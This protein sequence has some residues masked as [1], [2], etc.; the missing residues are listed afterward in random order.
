MNQ[1]APVVAEPTPV[2]VV[3]VAPVIVVPAPIVAP[4]VVTPAPVVIEPAAPVPAVVAIA[5]ATVVEAEV[6]AVEAADET[7]VLGQRR[8]RKEV[9]LIEDDSVP[10]ADA[11]VLGSKRRPQTGDD[12]DVWA[13]MFMTSVAG[14]AAWMVFNKKK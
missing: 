10:L 1:T 5:P 4:A 2:P 13:F 6:A 9:V 12:S 7:D 8:V 11:A 14:L 3:P